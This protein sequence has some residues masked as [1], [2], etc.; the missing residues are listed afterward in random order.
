MRRDLYYLRGARKIFF[1]HHQVISL[2]IK[3]SEVI[4]AFE[5]PFFRPG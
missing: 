3:S 1:G 2:G 5:H 4:F